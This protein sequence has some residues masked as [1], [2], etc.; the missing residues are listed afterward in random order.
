MSSVSSFAID[1]LNEH[2][3]TTPAIALQRIQKERESQE[4]PPSH[5]VV[6]RANLCWCDAR[7]EGAR[8]WRQL[9]QSSFFFLLSLLSH[10]HDW[11]SEWGVLY[12]PPLSTLLLWRTCLHCAAHT[13][14]HTC[15][16]TMLP[17]QAN[18]FHSL[19]QFERL[20]KHLSKE[21]ANLKWI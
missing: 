18:R 10:T 20:F 3:Q 1:W 11:V 7:I 4:R 2:C 6:G 8:T 16:R 17:T 13:Y 19:P 5:S 21:I 15:A 14:A 12:L 9:C